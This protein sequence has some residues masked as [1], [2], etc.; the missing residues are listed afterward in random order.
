MDL[1]DGLGWTEFKD[2]DANLLTDFGPYTA[3]R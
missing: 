2:D 3:V 1:M